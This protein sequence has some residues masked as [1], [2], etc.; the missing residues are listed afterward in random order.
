MRVKAVYNKSFLDADTLRWTFRAA[1]AGDMEALGNLFARAVKPRSDSDETMRVGLCSDTRAGVG[2]SVFAKGMLS[3]FR[4]QE[5]IEMTD[6]FLR[7]QGTWRTGDSGVVRLYDCYYEGTKVSLPSYGTGDAS[8]LGLPRTD[9]VEHAYSDK[10]DRFFDYLV[11]LGFSPDQT[12]GCSDRN[13]T[14][15]AA[16]DSPAR[17]KLESFFVQSVAWRRRPGVIAPIPYRE[18]SVP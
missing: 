2:K 7:S 1:T 6:T 15:V 9:I 4:R 3:A 13:V 16:A 12:P 11:L 10:H 18:L 17:K 5:C 8:A 14:I